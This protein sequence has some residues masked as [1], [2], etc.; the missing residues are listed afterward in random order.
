DGTPMVT[1]VMHH[2]TCLVLAKVLGRR[3]EGLMQMTLAHAD[4]ADAL[5]EYE[6]LAAVSG[7]PIL[8]NVLIIMSRLPESHR[9]VL[10][11]LES[12]RERGNRVY[13]P[14][15]TNHAGFSINLTGFHL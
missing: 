12:R 10:E 1:D 8:Y 5:R 3:N 4:H 6:E 7:R 9:G 2:E 13:A 14:A 15:A 11:W